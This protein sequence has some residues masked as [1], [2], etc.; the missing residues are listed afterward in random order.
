MSRTR[1]E[2]RALTEEQDEQGTT[3]ADRNILA[4]LNVKKVGY[5]I[6]GLLLFVFAL[7][8][9]KEG[10]GSATQIVQDRLQVTN[11]LNALGFGWL[12]AYIVM[13]G[14]PVAAAALALL[15]QDTI[16]SVQ[17]FAMISGSRL[18]ASFLVLL[19]GFVYVLRGQ[20]RRNGLSVGL[21]SLIVTATLH[22]PA[23]LLGYVLL[24]AEVLDGLQVEFG[25]FDVINR[26]FDPLVSPIVDAVPGLGVFA[27]GIAAI[28]AAFSL[29]DRGIP[30]LN[31]NRRGFQDTSRLLYRPPVMFLLGFAITFVSLSV[32]VSLGILVPLSARGLIRRENLI[33]Y[34]MGC[35]IS[36]FIDTLVVAMLLQSS[37]GFTVVLVE[38]LSVTVASIAILAL[39]YAYYERSIVA[40]VD[41]VLDDN[42]N[43]VMFLV[44]IFLIPIALMF[45]P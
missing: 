20:E 18:G 14:S 29:I 37:P 35:N 17:A 34:I 44:A 3:S 10:A 28:I 15:A 45:V 2:E 33:P 9:A 42:R 21:M 41:W 23:L 4:S 27:L 13:S 5:I 36:T 30:E 39:G 16:D 26:L 1:E 38:M 22:V 6:A 12:F 31:L 8:L 40:V 32:S 7:Q 25:A 43:F 19:L 11:A 24:R